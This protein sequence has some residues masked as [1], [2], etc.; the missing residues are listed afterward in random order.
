MAKV[1]DVSFAVVAAAAIL[2]TACGDS[3]KPGDEGSAPKNAAESPA[4]VQAPD[5]GD[6]EHPKG[7]SNRAK[8]D[9]ESPNCESVLFTGFREGNPQHRVNGLLWG[10]DNWVYG[11]NGDSGGRVRSAKSGVTVDI[12]GH[13]FR[14]RPDEKA[15][16]DPAGNRPA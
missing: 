12:R 11:A 8:G 9:L 3:P 7:R 4:A 15:A 16:P 1:L 2:L 5:N 10:V 13:D 14:F 6:A